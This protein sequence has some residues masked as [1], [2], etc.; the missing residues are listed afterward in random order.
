MK[1]LVIGATGQTGRHVVRLLLAQG[2]DVTAFVRSSCKPVAAD[3]HL[4][5]A[6]GD[7]RD[8]ESIER[9]ILGQDAR[10]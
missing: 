10:T 4:R 3:P 9:A 5:V 7:A 8:R 2:H 6:Q 1:V